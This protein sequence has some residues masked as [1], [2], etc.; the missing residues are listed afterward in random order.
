[1]SSH[2]DVCYPGPK[3]P[4]FHLHDVKTLN[5]YFDDELAVY[6]TFCDY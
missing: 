1:M 5:K 4:Y 2:M 3:H 6:T